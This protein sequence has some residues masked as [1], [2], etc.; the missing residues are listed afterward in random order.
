MN[1][2]RTGIPSK[3]WLYAYLRRFVG[4]R[5]SFELSPESVWHKLLVEQGAFNAALPISVSAVFVGLTKRPKD[6]PACPAHGP[7]TLYL[8]FN[9][10][11]FRQGDMT[12]RSPFSRSHYQHGREDIEFELSE[13]RGMALAERLRAMT[14]RLGH[15]PARLNC[16]EGS[17]GK[18][19][20]SKQEPT[21]P[22]RGSDS[23][24]DPCSS[25]HTAE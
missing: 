3:G 15:S 18:G 24:E 2:K 13:I 12:A 9:K 1:H 23:S 6:W 19:F 22:R 25:A 11:L 20:P 10:V 4:Q 14:P 7:V 8:N 5:V 17:S 21:L 16:S